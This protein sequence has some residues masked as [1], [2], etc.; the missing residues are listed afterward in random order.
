MDTSREKII[1]CLRESPRS[2]TAEIAARLH[3][4][5][6]DIRHHLA[7]LLAEGVAVAE[8]QK[9]SG[10]RGRPE[11]LYSLAEGN[12]PGLGEA[13]LSLLLSDIP[14]VQQDEVLQRLARLL[15]NQMAVG[16]I[17]SL[18]RGPG[19]RRLG[20]AVRCLNQHHY[21]ARWEAHSR[22]PRVQLRHCPYMPLPMRHPEL[23]RMDG[24][25]L[26][27]IVGQPFVQ[28]ARLGE[29]GA[30]ACIFAT[31]VTPDE[32]LHSEM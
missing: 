13:L 26:E 2:T 17:A 8:G 29:N 27:M 15:A 23:C 31:V 18:T 28:F 25:L 19:A 22:G 21:Q 32:A 7:A 11:R 5:P 9:Q 12:L 14:E 24:I 20:K 10:A 4:T 1:A 30:S 6:A 16:E 3:R